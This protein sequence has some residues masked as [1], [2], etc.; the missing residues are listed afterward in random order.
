MIFKWRIK[1]Y[2][3]NDQIYYM[4][5]RKGWIF[6]N[7][8]TWDEY[9]KVYYEEDN[10]YFSRCTTLQ[11]PGLVDYVA[12]ANLEDAKRLIEALEKYEDKKRKHEEELDEYIYIDDDSISKELKK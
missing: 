9:R 10:Y 5:Q 12:F 2:D 7:N 1:K 11:V 3:H 6:W 4:P 8:A